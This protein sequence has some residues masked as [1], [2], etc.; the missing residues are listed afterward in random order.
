[1]I[2][3]VLFL[4]MGVQ[5]DTEATLK[6]VLA[7]TEALKPVDPR[8]L[9]DALIQFAQYLH[10]RGRFREAELLYLRSNDLAQ[11]LDGSFSL[12]A[13]R[14]W[15]RLGAIYHAEL[16][17][18]QAETSARQAVALFHGLS[19]DD[20]IDYAYA[21]ANLAAILADEG[22]NARA[23]PVFRRAIYLIRRQGPEETELLA[24]IELNL[25]LVY[26]RQGELRQAEL[27]FLRLL[28]ENPAQANVLA[29]LAELAIAGRRWPQADSWIR[30][31]YEISVRS[32]ED[33]STSMVGILRLKAMVESHAGN[34][35]EAVAD[36][37]RSVD[38]LEALA[39]SQ[40]LTLSNLLVEYSWLLR[41]AGEKQQAYQA[42]KRAKSVR[43]S[44]GATVTR[45]T[46]P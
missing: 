10:Q 6:A 26:L 1:M 46:V 20:N 34:Q 41:R 7:Q 37:K 30:R 32:R 19:G 21:I 39:G 3:A 18:D 31:A 44:S 27:L 33:Q 38:L 29:A 43:A 22:E 12:A 8:Q 25:G 28:S 17:F 5:T 16:R 2:Y 45:I 40:S 14:S 35:H 24:G 13:A 15:L 11:S 42:R 4:I 36:M 23:E 9:N